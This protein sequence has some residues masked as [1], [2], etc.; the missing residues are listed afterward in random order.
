MKHILFSI[1]LSS[2]ASLATAQIYTDAIL[3]NQNT[4]EGTARSLA[5]GSAFGSLGADLSSAVINPAGLA[6]YRSSDASLSLGIN[7]NTAESSY[8]NFTPEND[9]VSVPFNNIGAAFHSRPMAEN[10]NKLQGFTFSISYNRLADYNQ[11]TIYKD[12]YGYNSMLDF[13]CMDENINNP[14]SGGLAYDAK[15]IYDAYIEDDIEKMMI[16]NVWEAPYGEGQFDKMAREDA[17]GVGLVD[18]EQSVKQRGSKGELLFGTAW[19]I[20]NTLY[21]GG[22]FGIQTLNYNEKKNH[23]EQYYGIPLNGITTDFTYRTEID[24]DGS[25]VNFKIGAIYQPI[26]YISIGF[27][28]HSP[29]FFSIEEYYSTSITDAETGYFENKQIGEYEYNYR[30]PGR[31]VASASGL[32]G[33]FGIISFDYERCN[34]SKSKFKEKE[35]EVEGTLYFYT[36]NDIKNNLK[37]V[38]IMRVGLEAKLNEQFSLRAGYKFSTSP[39]EENYV[40]TQDM[41]HSAFSGGIGYK[42]SNI[43][44]DF[45]YINS[46][47]EGENWVLPNSGNYI[48]ELNEPATY[49]SRSNNFILTAGFRF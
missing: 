3:F 1:A 2:L 16:H 48:Y 31:F 33:K 30:S 24:Q 44:I 17:D 49:K 26:P 34:Y 19:N 10:Q 43:Y 23:Y 18:H 6:R 25:G 37:A 36:N 28:L 4:Y 45:A 15:Y 38:N 5:M 47:K 42:F 20:C 14:Y 35:H 8:Y 39:L 9:K 32:I 12:M 46:Q 13:F 22:S 29:T 21:I 11:S 40:Y 7:F 27:A 41:K